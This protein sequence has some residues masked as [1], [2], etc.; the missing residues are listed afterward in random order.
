M[1]DL[2]SDSATLALSAAKIE[3]ATPDVKSEDPTAGEPLVGVP[4]RLTEAGH[5]SVVVDSPFPKADSLTLHL[6]GNVTPIDAPSTIDPATERTVF[7]VPRAL[8]REGLQFFHYVAHRISGNSE[9]S[10]KLWVLYSRNR[11]GGVDPVVDDQ[12]IHEGLGIAIEVKNVGLEE[13]MRGVLL[14]V[15]YAFAKPHDVVTV[16]CNGFPF[17][18]TVTRA[19]LGGAFDITLPEAVF[20][21]G[22]NS[23]DFLIFYTVRDQLGNDTQNSLPSRT[24]SIVVDLT[25]KEEVPPAPFVPAL[26]GKVIV[27]IKHTA[28]FI[29]R[30]DW[31]AGF[32]TGDR[33]KLVVTGGAA[34]DGTPV[35]GF[36][37]FNTNARANFQLTPAFIL[38]N[39]N[40]EVV[41]KWVLLRDGQEMESE[42]LTL[43]I[44]SVNVTDPNVQTPDIVE[45]YGTDSVDMRAFTGDAQIV[46]APWPLIRAGQKYWQH[47]LG[48][49]LDNS[50]K[51]VAIAVG[52]TLTALEIQN[53]LDHVLPPQGAGAVQTGES[54]EGSAAGGFL[55]QYKP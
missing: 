40:K 18:Y 4:L 3:G 53:G 9:E 52:N 6:K 26:V 22:G 2:S 38:A 7:K 54:I 32:K 10:P 39:G 45:A 20:I 33:A 8:L 55:R 27:P 28:G 34:G 46:C 17:E 15:S 24:L 37:N 31:A 12:N 41:F 49:G 51:T 50:P 5:L 43:Q 30:V 14:T 42:P 48:T 19:D 16:N 11:P 25:P 47:V 35:F 13:A 44:E 29:V 1:T 36:I 23:Q 21:G